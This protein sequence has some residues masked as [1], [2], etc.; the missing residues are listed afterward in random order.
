MVPAVGSEAPG[1][2]AA[3]S[4]MEGALVPFKRAK[5]VR[6]T[7]RPR[8]Q[9]WSPV[10]SM[11]T[12]RDLSKAARKWLEH[13]RLWNNTT[14]LTDTSYL[15]NPCKMVRCTKNSACLHC[16][17]FWKDAESFLQVMEAGECEHLNP[18]LDKRKGANS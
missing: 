15:N 6:R 12:T 1:Q 17:L 18:S 16:W 13:E 10:A 9:L 11:K 2:V 5:K 4:S 7:Y 8:S 3:A 14:R